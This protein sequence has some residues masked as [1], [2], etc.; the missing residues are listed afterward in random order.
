MAHGSNLNNGEPNLQI[1]PMWEF[2]GQGDAFLHRRPQTPVEHVNA[3]EEPNHLARPIS[4]I[5][6]VA[7]NDDTYQIPSSM[8]T[9]QHLTEHEDFLLYDYYDTDYSDS[10]NSEMGDDE[11]IQD[12]VKVGD[13]KWL[14]SDVNKTLVDQEQENTLPGA[15]KK[16]ARGKEEEQKERSTK[17]LIKDFECHFSMLTLQHLAKQEDF[18]LCDYYGTNYSD[19]GNS[20]MEDDENFRDENKAEDEEGVNSGIKK[21]LGNQEKQENTF[22]GGSKKRAKEEDEEQEERKMKRLRYNFDW[23]MHKTQNY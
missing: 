2:D 18:M 20:D 11:T 16:R 22:P 7:G 19:S 23:V 9:L 4:P 5:Q 13:R 14:N 12:E 21:D 6:H 8:L 15:A 17:P 10:G 3:H 1:F